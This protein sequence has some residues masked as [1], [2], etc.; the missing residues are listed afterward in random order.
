MN[1]YV[2]YMKQRVKF[3]SHVKA[4]IYCKALLEEHNSKASYFL[5]HS[6]FACNFKWSLAEMSNRG[7][8][9]IDE[10]KWYKNWIYSRAGRNRLYILRLHE[11]FL[12]LNS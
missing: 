1:K 10:K 2:K 6:Y 5:G 11:K 4:K 8:F 12:T 7:L 3:P 9:G